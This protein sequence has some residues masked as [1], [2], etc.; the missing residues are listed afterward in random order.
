MIEGS[1]L[2][3][4]PPLLAASCFG[5]ATVDLRGQMQPGARRILGGMSAVSVTAALLARAWE[6]RRARA[7]TAEIP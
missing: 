6:K 2:G 1:L 5:G 4:I 7:A 3:Y